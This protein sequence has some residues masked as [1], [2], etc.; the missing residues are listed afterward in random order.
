MGLLKRLL[1]HPLTRGLELDDPRTTDLRR[2]IIREKPFLRHIYDDW[3]AFIAREIAKLDAPDGPGGNR[4]V[5]E[6]G[7][8]PGFL[9]DVLPGLI[10]S[11]LLFVPGNAL[12]LDA[13]R[14]P[15]ASGTLR[16]ITMV[17]VLHHVPDVARFLHEAARCVAPGG[18]IVMVEPWVTPWA[19][20]AWR[21]L[22][23]EPFVPD[24]AEWTVPSGGPLSGAN[25]ALPWMVLV[26]DRERFD[27]EHAEWR[28]ESIETGLPL[29][30]VLS[31]GVSLRSSMPGWSSGAWRFIEA[32]MRPGN[33]AWAMYASIVLRRV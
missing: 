16:A 31:G 29:R 4:R 15:F 7:S 10:T 11:E 14:L 18:A 3:Y 9:A 2:R 24:A 32:C 33:R 22:H 21:H 26:R 12:M 13:Q 1:G 6:I 19:S 28:I 30:Y 27:R 17:E 25:S 5:L 20:L 8:G 23:H